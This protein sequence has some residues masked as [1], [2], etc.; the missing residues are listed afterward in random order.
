[1][2]TPEEKVYLMLYVKK[3]QH[4]VWPQA[5][6]GLCNYMDCMQIGIKH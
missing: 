3:N 5:I 4:L 2:V 6:K 1:M